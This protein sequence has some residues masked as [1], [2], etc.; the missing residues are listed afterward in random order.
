[1]SPGRT[2]RLPKRAFIFCL[3]SRVTRTHASDKVSFTIWRTEESR[4]EELLEIIKTNL[5]MI[6]VLLVKLIELK[7]VGNLKK[8]EKKRKVTCLK[9]RSST[10]GLLKLSLG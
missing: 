4:E 2:D 1:M 10:R 7:W 6:F 3:S 5:S 9:I 8:K